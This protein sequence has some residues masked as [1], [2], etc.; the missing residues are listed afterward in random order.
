MMIGKREDG[1]TELLWYARRDTPKPARVARRV[2]LTDRQWR[3]LTAKLDINS[4]R[5]ERI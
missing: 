5:T 2:V 3:E 4:G 1:K